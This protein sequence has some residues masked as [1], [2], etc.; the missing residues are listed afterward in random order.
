MRE[1]FETQ[2]VLKTLV[3]VLAILIATALLARLIRFL[4]TKLIHRLTAKDKEYNGRVSHK[5]LV[6]FV[7]SVVY[8]LGIITAVNQV[9]RLAGT[10]TTILA[11]SGVLAVII[12]FAAQE[13][14][15]NLISGVFLTL[16]KPFDVGDRV[17]LPE[18]NITGYVEDITLRHTV[19]R[20]LTQTR[21]LIPNAIMGSAIVE[22]T[23]YVNGSL[24]QVPITVD[25]AF[26]TDLEKAVRVMGKALATHP[27]CTGAAPPQVLVTGFGASGISLLGFLPIQDAKQYTAAASAARI[28]V[29][30]A[31]D[32]N[33]IV[34][35][36]Q[37]VTIS[38]HG[39]GESIRIQTTREP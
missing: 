23:D 15:G 33:G 10:L 37:T 26:E 28:L 29:K 24:T 34:I 12:G 17:T 35:P 36:Y 1:L 38:N 13:S 5:M 3:I 25:V 21:A 32:E 18:K 11:G 30:K 19:I 4:L 27:L 16:F 7:V 31:F 6:K 39:E 2:P 14:F 8:V 22:N 20:T 9:P